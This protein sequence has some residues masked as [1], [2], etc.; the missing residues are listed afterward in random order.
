MV[1]VMM[2]VLSDV[3]VMLLRKMVSVV[4]GDYSRCDE[5]H[6]GVDDEDQGVDDS[7]DDGDS[8]VDEDGGVVSVT[9]MVRLLKI[10]MRKMAA[11]VVLMTKV[12]VCVMKT[13]VSDEDDKGDDGITGVIVMASVMLDDEDIGDG[14][15]HSVDDGMSDE[16]EVCGDDDDNGVSSVMVM[17]SIVW[18]MKMKEMMK[19]MTVMRVLLVLW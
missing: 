2:M 4:L 15:H 5:V 11:M 6:C 17:V 9:M 19:K 14:G 16:D 8:D 18:M 1:V 3:M 13:K 7:N 10:A 12:K